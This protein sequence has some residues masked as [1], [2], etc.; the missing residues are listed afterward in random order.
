MLVS[1]YRKQK[2]FR[3]LEAFFAAARRKRPAEVCERRLNP[4][5]EEVRRQTKGL[6]SRISCPPKLLNPFPKSSKQTRIKRLA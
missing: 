4:Q 5:D 6:K 2:I 1:K 3:N